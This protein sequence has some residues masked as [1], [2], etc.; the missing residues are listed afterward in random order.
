MILLAKAALGLGGALVLAGGYTFREG[1]IRVDVDE[2]HAQGSHLHMWVPAAMVPMA[3]HFVPKHALCDS[4][5]HAR[6]MLPA[7][8]AFSKELK[9]RP[10]VDLL[11]VTD[12]EEHAEVRTRSGKLFVD[13]DSPEEHVHLQVPL[14]TLDEVVEQLEE[15]APGAEA[16]AVKPSRLLL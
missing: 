11:E 8:H 14:S 3:L 4:A 7:I 16:Q 12:G 10:D 2:N 15:S 1:L 5:Q 9:K 6:E 13:V